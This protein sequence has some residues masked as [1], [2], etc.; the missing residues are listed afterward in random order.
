MFGF[1]KKTCAF[2]SAQVPAKQTLRVPDRSTGVVCRACYEQWER[3]GRTCAQC[4]TPVR[5]MQEVG[6]FFETSSLGHA[7]CG[8]VMLFA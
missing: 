7:D 2:C 6:A 8:G 3:A 5:G 4:Q 1:G